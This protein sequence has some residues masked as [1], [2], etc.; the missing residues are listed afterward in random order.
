[1]VAADLVVT[2]L[3]LISAQSLGYSNGEG[4]FWPKASIL[5]AFNLLF[6]YLADL[7][8]LDSRIRR[9]EVASRLIIAMVAS[10]ISTAAIGYVLPSLGL[11]RLTFIHTFG[12]VALGCLATRLLW[13]ARVARRKLRH[14]VL[15]LGVG[16]AA[17]V[18]PELQFSPT[19]PFTILG[20]LDDAPDASD[21]VPRG[22]EL[23]GKTKDLLN[24]TDE[25]RPDLVLVALAE[26][27][28]ALPAEELLECRLQGINVEDWPTFYEKQTGKILVTNLRP[29][30]LIFSDGFVKTDTTRIVKRA[31]DVGL[32]FIGLVLALP[33][34]IV[35][36][37]AIKLTSK[38]PVLFRQQRVGER[39]RVFVLKKFRSMSVDAEINGPVWAAA[40]DPRV[41]RVGRLLRRTRLDELPQFWNVLAGDM[42]FVGPRP[43]RPEFVATLQREIP[44]YMGRHSVRPGITGWAQ[45]RHRYAA[46]IEDSMEKLQYDLYYIKNLSPLL[47]LV[48][49]LSTLQVVLFTRGAR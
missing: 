49:L 19:R 43:E 20:F 3:A 39:G 47:D 30:W 16:P 35:A 26:M 8:Q 44:F 27:R 32:A 2:A 6:L 37:C 28:R 9:A 24:L 18:L 23:L 1:M 13:L 36:A 33:L 25:L 17:K 45:V 46:S 42:S 12:V 31:M 5:A 10:S 15:V 29:S 22:F 41:T 48:I 40:R 7:Y 14:R 4:P 11:G 21:G 38:G 34:M